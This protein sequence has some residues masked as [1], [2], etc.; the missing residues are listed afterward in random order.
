M[1][2]LKRKIRLFFAVRIPREGRCKIVSPGADLSRFYN[3]QQIDNEN[4]VGY[5]V[6]KA[7]RKL[8]ISRSIGIIHF[9]PADPESSSAYLFVE[10]EGD[11]KF[12]YW[13]VMP[14][15]SIKFY[16]CGISSHHPTIRDGEPLNNSDPQ[17][18]TIQ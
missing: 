12:S 11:K 8:I 6:V 4:S 3:M 2:N 9:L 1:E 10:G 15:L 16:P 5:P 7:G 13:D 18:T 14:K 17:G